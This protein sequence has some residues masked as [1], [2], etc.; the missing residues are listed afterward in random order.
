[1]VATWGEKLSK[2]MSDVLSPDEEFKAGLF[3]T[4]VGQMTGQAIGGV[5][6]MAVAAKAA[7]KAKN[8][9]EA[10]GELIHGI[11]T[12]LPEKSI[13]GLTGKRLLFFA[14]GGFSGVK[15]LTHEIPLEDVL[16]F[17]AER[18]KLVHH[19]TITFKDGSEVVYESP[20]GGKPQ[21][22]IDAL[23]NFKSGTVL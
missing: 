4:N 18:K 7:K 15:E 14:M 6:G 13:V 9:K 8:A 22:F 21:L 5:I 12:S 23:S 3:G 19:V 20:K 1:M 16:S 2:K 10:A 17:V 11:G